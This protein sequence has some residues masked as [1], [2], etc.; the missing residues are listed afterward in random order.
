ML[1]IR[2]DLIKKGYS[3]L[4]FDNSINSIETKETENYIPDKPESTKTTLAPSTQV[5]KESLL[6]FVTKTKRN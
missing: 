3:I 1:E 2:F 5:N 4:F 6:C